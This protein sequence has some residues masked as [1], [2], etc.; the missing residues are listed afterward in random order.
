MILVTGGAGYIGSHFI[1]RYLELEPQ[2]S[3]LAIDNL[4]EGH[5]ESLKGLPAVFFEKCDIGDYDAIT[6][7]LK[8]HKIEAVIHFAASAYVG[9]SQ[10]NPNKYFHNNVVN[11]LNFFRALEEAR[12]RKIVFSSTCASYGN[13]QYLPIDENH[14]QDPINVYG[15][16]KFM[17]EKTLAGYA[18]TRNWSYVALR[19]FNAAGADAGGAIGESHA[20]ETHIIPLTLKAAAGEIECVEV[21]GD[22]YD[23][24]DGTCIR[25]YIHVTDL[26]DAHHQA[27]QWLQ[28]NTGGERINLGTTHGASVKEVIE[29]CRKVTGR[30]IEVRMKPRRPGDPPALV[31]NAEKAARVLGWKPKYD[32]TGIIQTAWNWEQNRKF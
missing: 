2:G 1:R 30:N 4:S 15:L 20:P 8:K 23:T 18:M 14:P 28:S 5:T 6:A 26:A 3:V 12:V 19:Y 13:P 32:L 7:L 31:A 25:D 22:D 17:I 29:V 24:P 21:Y 9:E 16:T 11:T 10:Q 27:L